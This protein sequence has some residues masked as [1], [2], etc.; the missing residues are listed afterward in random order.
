MVPT[1]I[2]D[3]HLVY[4]TRKH[5]GGVQKGQ[6]VSVKNRNFKQLDRNKF[7]QD[8]TNHDWSPIPDSSDPEVCCQLFE[9]TLLTVTDHHIPTKER[10]VKG[11]RLPWITEE[12]IEAI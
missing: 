7:L 9:S 6:H 5:N 10:R 3:H 12:C 8:L 2:S 11:G 4:L 1:S